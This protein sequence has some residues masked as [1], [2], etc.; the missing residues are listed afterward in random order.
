L[1]FY[2]IFH[3]QI[4]WLQVYLQIASPEL[5]QELFDR[6]LEKLNTADVD[7]FVRESVLDLLRALM[8]YQDKSRL[9]QLYSICEDRLSNTKNLH[10][11]K[12]A[13]R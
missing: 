5:C 13:Y 6:A 10:E 11:Q 2:Y 9:A 1:R 3:V 8:S 7:V 4:I 12:K